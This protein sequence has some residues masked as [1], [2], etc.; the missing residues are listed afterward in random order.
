MCDYIRTHGRG[1]KTNL[2]F[3][4]YS[5]F[6]IASNYTEGSARNEPALG[7]FSFNALYLLRAL[8]LKFFFFLSVVHA[9]NEPSTT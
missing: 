3:P 7:F 1:R 8:L 5:N 9:G 4:S 2:S 6:C